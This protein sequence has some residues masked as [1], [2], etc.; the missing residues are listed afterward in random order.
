[1]SDICTN[2]LSHD[3]VI[4]INDNWICENCG[5]V[6]QLMFFN[7]K[8]HKLFIKCDNKYDWLKYLEKIIDKYNI[9]NKY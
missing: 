7:F 9:P 8:D 4:D 3:Y 5:C 2:C 1:M 6:S